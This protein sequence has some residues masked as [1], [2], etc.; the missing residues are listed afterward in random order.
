MSQTIL[1]FPRLEVTA[2][3]AMPAWWF[4]AP[5]SPTSYVGFGQA[6]ALKCL[7]PEE[8]DSFLGVGVVLHDFRLRA[9]KIKGTAAYLP[10]QLRAA[11]LIN[12]DDYS[13]KNKYAL[14]LQPTVRCDLTVS[15]AVTFKED[16][17]IDAEKVRKFMHNARIAGGVVTETRNEIL[18]SSQSE[19]RRKLQTGFA[20]HSRLDLMRPVEG[21][22]QL[23][24]LLKA[25][26]PSQ[27]TWKAL[28]WVMPATFGYLAVTDVGQRV[29]TRDGYLHAFAE[30]LVGLVQLKS[31]KEAAIPVWRYQHPSSKVFLVGH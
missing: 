21:A 7:P 2:A 14:S 22:D 11:S 27:D 10:H 18:A 9:E 12:S 31:L 17:N 25:T 19:V 30:P 4:I 16:A 29:W 13:S 1:L 28:P 8:A 23:D 3:N 5:P 20:L 6:M 26:L 15:I 24:A